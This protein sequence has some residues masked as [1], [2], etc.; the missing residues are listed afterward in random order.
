MDNSNK[1]LKIFLVVLKTLEYLYLATFG[2]ILYASYVPHSSETIRM[3]TKAWIDT[4][5]MILPVLLFKNVLVAILNNGILTKNDKI[6]ILARC[7]IYVLLI[8]YSQSLVI[9]AVSF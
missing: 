9:D 4:S 8:I 3:L 2:F 5:Y 7:V 6:L 1:K